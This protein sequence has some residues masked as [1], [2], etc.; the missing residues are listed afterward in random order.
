[1]EMS[2]TAELFTMMNPDKRLFFS[3]FK[4]PSFLNQRLIGLNH[5]ADYSDTELNHALLNSV[6]TMFYIEASGFGRGLGVLD[7]NKDSIAKCFMFNP[8]IVDND[9]REKIVNAF[10]ALKDRTIMNVADELKSP[11]R[12]F[13]EEAVFQAFELERYLPS[14]IGSLLSMQS[15]RAAARDK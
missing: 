4:V 12:L 13:F 9:N 5:K 11:D 14:V 2:E 1:M 10:Q 15:A 7:I 3:S 6:F 8:R